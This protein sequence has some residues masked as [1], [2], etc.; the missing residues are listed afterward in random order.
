MKKSTNKVEV[1]PI[2]LEPHPN[3]NSLSIVRVFGYTVCVKTSEW[4]NGDLAAYIVPDTLVDT[5]KPEFQ[6]LNQYLHDGSY[7]HLKVRKM[8]GIISQGLLVKPPIDAKIG[9]DL[10]DYFEVKRY[11]PPYSDSGEFEYGPQYASKYDVDS[12]LR[13]KNKFTPGE[14]VYISEKID[15]ANARFLYHNNRIYCGSRSNWKKE[16]N[17]SEWWI[18][19][20]KIPGI[21][22]FCK[23]FPGFTLFGEIFGNNSKMPYSTAK[24]DIRVNIFDICRSDGTWFGPH[25]R[26]DILKKYDVPTPPTIE[27]QWEIDFNTIANFAEGNTLFPANHVREGCVI[28]PLIPRFDD[29]LGRIKLKIVGNQYLQKH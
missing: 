13:Y 14:F 4:K 18:A 26:L 22:D 24:R 27:Y 29:E 12:F 28:E 6:F 21:F 16:S 7:H 23:D 10:S 20:K 9:D 15:G 8:R 3:A 11:E 25:E 5:N 17:S 1:V 19:Y 2:Q